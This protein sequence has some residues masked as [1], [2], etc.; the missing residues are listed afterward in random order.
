MSQPAPP[1]QK[2]PR[3]LKREI[4]VV[5]IAKVILLVVIWALWFDQPMPKEDRAA[6]TARVIL[7]K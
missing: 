3:S 4:T 5:L 6:N 2:K 1:P 7:N